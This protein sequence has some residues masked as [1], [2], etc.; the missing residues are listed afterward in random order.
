MSVCGVMGVL[1]PVGLCGVMG[2]LAPVSVW[3]DG[4][5][6]TCQPVSVRGVMGVLAPVGLCQC[7]V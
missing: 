6:C 1:A 2:V 3:Y 5:P 7:V 4:C